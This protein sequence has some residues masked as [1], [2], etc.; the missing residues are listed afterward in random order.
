MTSSPAP[1]LDDLTAA[2]IA[3][4]ERGWTP[5]P[6]MPGE[7]RPGLPSWPHLTYETADEVTQTFKQAHQ[8]GKGGGI[9]L[10]LGE[11]SGGLVDVD[12]D[13]HTA[14]SLRDAFLPPTSMV[15]GRTSIRRSHY[16][17]RVSADLP[18]ATKRYTL[19]SGEVTV[20]LRTTG[21][22]TVIPPSVHPSGEPY[23]WE[24]REWGGADGPHEEDGTVL[25]ARVAA[26]AL[27]TVAV[28]GW[29]KQGGRHASY[30]ALAGGLLRYGE[31]GV[32]PLWEVALPNLIRAIAQATHD[33]DGGDTRVHEVMDST[34][35]RLRSGQ[36]VQGFPTL[37]QLIGADHAELIRRYAREVE[38]ILGHAA[39]PVPE[40]VMTEV[41]GTDL[42]QT[43]LP[44]EDRDP[45][46]ERVSS[47][48][49]VDLEPYV[50]GGVVLPDPSLLTRSDGQPLLYS[51][52]INCLYGRSESGKSWIAVLAA[53]EAMGSG[54]RVLYI[55]CE[56]EPMNTLGRLQA[57]GAG[58]EDVL[59]Q[60]AYV[61]PDSPLARMLVNKWGE[62]NA[63]AD[64]RANEEALAAALASID[65]G[66][67]VVDGL[68]TLYGLHGLDTNDATST[69][70]ITNFLKFLTRGNETT[71][72]FIDHTG[73]SA[74]LG[75][76]PIGSQHKIA[77]V[78][79]AAI[80][81]HADDR[82]RQGHVGHLRLAVGKDR[83]GKV[84]AAS[85]SGDPQIAAE[86]T[87]DSTDPSGQ[88]RL[89][90]A[91]PSDSSFYLPDDAAQSKPRRRPASGPPRS[92]GRPRADLST[93]MAQVAAEVTLAGDAGISKADIVQQSGLDE[94]TVT[95]AIGRLKKADVIVKVGGNRD[96][97]YRMKRTSPA[98]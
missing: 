29:P 64:S 88:V 69:D 75:A 72:L 65:P 55:D 51:G 58:D 82:P 77:M 15:T 83:L 79:G 54:Q 3:A 10:I 47:W 31:D 5:V 24:G 19:P 26:L 80:Q 89:T 95:K 74:G 90:L 73:K 14:W 56:D 13:H 28:D 33:D 21:G 25:A 37:G 38:T 63:T 50:L 94:V 27:A 45:L 70:R 86:V 32:H 85:S 78:Q 66:L 53:L 7:K 81:V 41:A 23:L 97:R 12:L 1:S 44:P 62:A 46:T 84:R 61:R 2:A 6:I 22:Q 92:P 42:T 57:L 4:H 67:I 60:F 98:G 40:P 18:E 8:S 30:L 16:W 93:E 43:T 76:M 96:A 35:T 48:Q 11:P 36:P 52:R 68:T 87:F 59:H 71:V 39:R 17:Y 20:E 9:G 34:L 91:P 49:P